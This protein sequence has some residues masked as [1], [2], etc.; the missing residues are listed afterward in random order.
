MKECQIIFPFLLPTHQ[1]TTRAVDPRMGAFH[2]PAACS[3]AGSEDLFLLFSISTANVRNV[4]MGFNLLADHWIIVARIQTQVL[5]LQFGRLRSSDDD[6]QGNSSPISQE[7]ALDP[8]F[9]AI[10]GIGS[11]RDATERYSIG[12]LSVTHT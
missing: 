6:S 1:K 12:S 5:R 3:I 8:Q 11:G 7:T 2:Y 4:L 9:A 10:G